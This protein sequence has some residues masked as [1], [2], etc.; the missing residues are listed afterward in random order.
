M[1]TFYNRIDVLPMSPKEQAE[2]LDA[3]VDALGPEFR[4]RFEAAVAA[5]KADPIEVPHER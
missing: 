3:L 4:E 1:S 2:R 5:F